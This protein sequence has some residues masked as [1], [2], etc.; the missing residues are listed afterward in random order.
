MDDDL[1]K[2]GKRLAKGLLIAFC[3][4]VLLY[5]GNNILL[6]GLP[7][8]LVH[9]ETLAHPVAVKSWTSSVLVLNDG[10]EVAVPG[11]ATLP[12]KS[13]ALQAA[14]SHGVEV[15]KDGRVTGLVQV[16][17]W[18]GNDPVQHDLRRVDIGHLVAFFERPPMDDPASINK[19]GD[20]E[21]GPSRKG[22]LFGSRGWNVSEEGMFR[23]YEHW[24]ANGA[25]GAWWE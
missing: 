9:I 11:C 19:N 2:P 6:T 5:C 23:H 21:P 15:G 22:G 8:P 24:M 12:S 3:L 25:K 7:F 20:R 1:E 17:H 18:C 10:R 4:L 16:W 13:K 14:L